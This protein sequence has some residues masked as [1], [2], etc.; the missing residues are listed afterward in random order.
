[1]LSILGACGFLLPKLPKVVSAISST[2]SDS[3]MTLSDV[4]VY[5]MEKAPALIVPQTM[6]DNQGTIITTLVISI[7]PQLAMFGL[8]RLA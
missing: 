7:L 6:I 1:M 3:N 4:L 8:R 5:V 2:A